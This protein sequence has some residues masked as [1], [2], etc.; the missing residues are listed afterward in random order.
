MT[1]EY[2][3]SHGYVVAMI[4]GLS[5]DI[6]DPGAGLEIAVRDMELAVP[7]MRKLAFVDPT[8]LALSQCCS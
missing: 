5:P 4:D 3:A 7:A 2:L 8:K 1:N 6:P